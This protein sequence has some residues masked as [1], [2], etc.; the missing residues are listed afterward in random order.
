MPPQFFENREVAK[1]YFRRFGK[2]KLV[3]FR[4]KRHT[5]LIEYANEDG[6]L[7]ALEIAGEYNGHI[8]KITRD[9]Q[10]IIKKKTPKKD[11][12]PDWTDDPEIRAELEAMGGITPLRSYELRQ[13]G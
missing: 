2:V 9:T 7:N 6:M 4:P 11:P 8:F 3:T 13:Q 1:R 5:L 10:T 12:D